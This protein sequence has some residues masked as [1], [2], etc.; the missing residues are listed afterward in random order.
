M[1]RLAAESGGELDAFWR[2]PFLA[3]ALDRHPSLSAAAKS[4]PRVVL[5]ARM[6]HN[7]LSL[8]TGRRRWL[9]DGHA[10]TAAAAAG[11]TAL[12]Q[13]SLGCA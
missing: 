3:I 1:E 11:I 12:M 10:E 4:M 2:S 7:E 8:F 5:A 13:M 6:M 9:A